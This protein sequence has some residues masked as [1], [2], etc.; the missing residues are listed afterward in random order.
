M[1]YNSHIEPEH[2]TKLRIRK[3]NNEVDKLVETE[4]EKNAFYRNFVPEWKRILLRQGNSMERAEEIT[5]LFSRSNSKD[6][7]ADSDKALIARGKILSSM[8]RLCTV[9]K[10]QRN[11][12]EAI[13]E[14]KVAARS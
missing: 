13:D 10:T 2:P 6:N 14:M 1:F 4:R 5:G 7:Q 11:T 9:S 8:S 12:I 3:I